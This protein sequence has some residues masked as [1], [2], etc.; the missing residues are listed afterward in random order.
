MY[1]FVLSIIF[2]KFE[3]KLI[4]KRQNWR[5]ILIEEFILI[6]WFHLILSIQLQSCI[7]AFIAFPFL[8]HLLY[9]DTGTSMYTQYEFTVYCSI[10]NRI[11]EVGLTFRAP[12]PR[13]YTGRQC[14]TWKFLSFSTKIFTIKRTNM[15]KIRTNTDQH[16]DFVDRAIT[17][18]AASCSSD[19][20]DTLQYLCTILSIKQKVGSICKLY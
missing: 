15:H 11:S 13:I 1:F 14:L 20:Y 6:F 8:S 12:V 16:L 3:N 17:I 9:I 18:L 7:T 2:C 5:F 10:E 4:I 19:N